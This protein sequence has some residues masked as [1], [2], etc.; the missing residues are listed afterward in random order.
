MINSIV[1]FEKLA[2][3]AIKELTFEQH[4]IYCAWCMDRLYASYAPLMAERLGLEMATLT[5]A[6][7]EQITKTI[8][9]R[10]FTVDKSYKERHSLQRMGI[11]LELNTLKVE[12]C[13]I[14]KLT[15]AIDNTFRFIVTKNTGLVM[16]MPLLSIE[17][18][19]TILSNEFMID[20]SDIDQIISHKLLQ[21]EFEAQLKQ[22]K[23]VKEYSYK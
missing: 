17:I 1:E 22:L 21:K 12:D 6:C 2:F 7:H 9:E 20:T 3:K 4:C 5:K 8:K 19:D 15:E 13:A 23:E 16:L 14:L 18:I 10:T 11:H